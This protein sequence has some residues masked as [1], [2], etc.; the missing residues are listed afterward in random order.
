MHPLAAR[1]QVSRRANWLSAARYVALSQWGFA[2]S[3]A[4][5]VALHPG[6]VLNG[7]EGG[8]SDYGVH[9]KTA[10][11]YYL[12]LTLAALGSF[13]AATHAV[14]AHDLPRRL[15]QLLLSYAVLATLTLASTL[16]YTLDQTQRDLHVGVGSALTLF[17]LVASL[18]MCRER[19]ADYGLLF[20]ELAGC[21]LG[22]LTIAGTLHLLFASEILT[23]ATFAI[24][25]F[26][27]TRQLAKNRR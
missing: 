27:T 9:L 4:L 21:I 2:A 12:A 1:S 19:S 20:A 14:D 25:L 11:P 3:V 7:N 13:L 8:V 23:G 16:G 22:A 18:W 17:E 15:R 24:V 6:F 5:C 26:R 10:L